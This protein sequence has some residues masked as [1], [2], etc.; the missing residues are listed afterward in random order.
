MGRSTAPTGFTAILFNPP[1]STGART[2]AR[3]T[4]A[5]KLLGHEE[6]T[7]ANLFPLA[8][9][10]VLEV[11]AI[12]KDYD[13]WLSARAEIGERLAVSG[14]ILLAYGCQEPVGE[15]R[16][17]FRAQIA[18]LRQEICISDSKVWSVSDEPRHPS[19]WQRHTAREYP[20]LPFNAALELSLR[21]LPSA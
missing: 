12:G 17:H 3:V 11:N 10:S 16:A 21:Q 6:A 14:D 20:G 2:I 9:K 19:R 1:L 7:I 8:T 4:L 13:L 18:W 5:A 15:V